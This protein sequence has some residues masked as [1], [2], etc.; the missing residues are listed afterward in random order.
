MSENPP[1]TPEPDLG[2]TGILHAWRAGDV[3]ALD[4]LM[5]LVYHHLHAMA[6][7]QMRREGPGHTLTATALVHEAY[8]RLCSADVSWQDRAHFYAIAARTMRRILVDH[9]R[10]ARR[11]K[12]GDGAQML[13]IEDA[14][15]DAALTTAPL[16]IDIL[17]LD[18]ALNRLSRLDERKGRLMEMVYFGGLNSE[19]AAHVLSISVA[20]IHRELRFSRAWL[21]VEM[22]RISVSGA[23]AN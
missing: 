2:I 20:T 11:K 9:A 14:G 23:E 18:T 4:Q 19:E 15:Q 12:R 13:S 17:D 16:P 7:Q 22:R 10:G 3:S 8:L 1:P 6:A 5:P 21:Q